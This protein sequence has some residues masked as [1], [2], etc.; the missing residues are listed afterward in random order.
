MK[1]Q[2]SN[3]ARTRRFW[4]NSDKVCSKSKD[5]KAK[6]KKEKKKKFWEQ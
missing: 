1:T 4:N 5:W 2:N 6:K 3:F